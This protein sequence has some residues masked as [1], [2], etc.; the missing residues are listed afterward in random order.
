MSVLFFTVLDGWI[1]Q[2]LDPKKITVRAIQYVCHYKRL[3]RKILNAE[4]ID[5]YYF[6]TV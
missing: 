2:F 4:Y 3:V 6:N 1:H 5:F